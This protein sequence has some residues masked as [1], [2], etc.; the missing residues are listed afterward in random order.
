MEVSRTLI[1]Q[2]YP[3]IPDSEIIWILR[4]RKPKNVKELDLFLSASDEEK[5]RKWGFPDSPLT[6]MKVLEQSKEN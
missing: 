5:R 4:N 3:L 6:L 2:V 1:K